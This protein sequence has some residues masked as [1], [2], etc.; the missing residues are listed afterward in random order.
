MEQNNF[1]DVGMKMRVFKNRFGELRAGW[2]IAAILILIIVAQ[3]AGS[4]LVPENGA[5]E[6]I[7]LIF[8]VTL[9]YGLIAIG[10][11]IILFKLLY[12][13][14]LRQLGLIP[15]G[16]CSGL[17]H[18][19][20]M[21]TA[22]MVLV[23]ALLLFTE[24]AETAFN[25]AKF[26]IPLL[27]ANLLSV[28]LTAFSEEFLVRGFMMTALKTTRNKWIIL[29]TSS[30]LFSLVHLL[31]P[32]VTALSLVNTLLAGLLFAYMFIKSGKLWLP[33]G[34]HLAWNFFQGDVFGM[35][36]SGR[37]QLSAFSTTMG[38]NELLTGGGAGPEGGLLVTLVLLLGALYV[39]CTIKTPNES[40]WAMDSDLPLTRN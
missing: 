16:W 20:G 30:I 17:L 11:G 2:A 3:V 25:Q 4:S 22:S 13:R 26:F 34:Y 38:T 35:H 14:S 12:K 15:E 40:H 24:Q 9:V 37:A 39:R 7:A 1:V 33:T 36:V 29:C 28:S 31:N 18:G 6:N 32:W 21:G 19:I 10:G 5:D 27:L 8:A 23:Y